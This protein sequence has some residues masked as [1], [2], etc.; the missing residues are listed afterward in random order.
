MGLVFVG[1]SENSVV[2]YGLRI[3]G[4]TPPCP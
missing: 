4:F 3:D 1:N 2:F